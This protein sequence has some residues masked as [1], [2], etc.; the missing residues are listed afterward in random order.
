MTVTERYND[1]INLSSGLREHDFIT[2]VVPR[3][4]LSSAGLRG[5]YSLSYQAEADFY[6]ERSDL[7]TVRHAAG[8]DARYRLSNTTELKIQDRFVNTPDATDISP[9]GI[10]PTRTKQYNNSASAL[11]SRQLSSMTGAS[12]G[13]SYGVQRFQTPNLIDS[14]V[15]GVQLAISHGFTRMDTLGANAGFRYFSFGGG[16]SQKVY[17]VSL[18]WT[19]RFSETF[20]LDGRGGASLYQDPNNRYSPSVFLDVGLKKSWKDAS[21]DLR[22]LHD[23]TISGGLASTTLI[24]QSVVL[25]IQKTLAEKL[26]A[27]LS[28]SYATNKSVKSTSGPSIDTVS[29]SGTAGLDYAMAAWLKGQIQYSYMQQ[30]SF[31]TVGND[32]RRHQAF[33]GLT[34]TLPQKLKVF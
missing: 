29:Y 26:R 30:N 8:L 21:A 34:A 14:T 13:Y 22:Y 10:I 3:L 5:E 9:T 31:E 27:N 28:G 4:T 17:T 15:Q 12:L 24:N 33:V 20:S 7:N 19:H 25:G 1:N 18:G 2:T 11:L 16:V 6:R 32:F 23:L